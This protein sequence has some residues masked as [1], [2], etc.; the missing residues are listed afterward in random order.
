M[1]RDAGG[2]GFHYSWSRKHSGN[3]NYEGK[4]TFLAYFATIDGFFLFAN[5]ELNFIVLNKR[6]T[7]THT[8]T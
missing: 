4:N 7:H 3:S 8:Q 6:H 5:R 1:L 2:R